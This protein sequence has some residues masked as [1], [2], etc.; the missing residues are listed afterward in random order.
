LGAAAGF[1]AVEL[2]L[3]SA[4]SY[5]GDRSP[6]VLLAAVCGALLAVTR[7]R[8]VMTASALLLMAGWAVVAWT[9]FTAWWAAG[10]TRE[11]PL[12]SADAVYVLAS[13]LQT[14]GEP[15]TVAMSRLLGAMEVLAGGATSRLIVAELPTPAA[16][17]AALARRLLEG[18][19]IEADLSVVG[20]ILNTRD[21]AL[22]VHALC[23]KRGWWRIILVTSPTHSSR[24]AAAFEFT[25]LE[26][27]SRPSM[28][29]RFDL[30]TLDRSSDRIEAFGR[31]LHERLG[32]IVYRQRGWIQ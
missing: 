17:H 10:L 11:D 13:R 24:A 27:I 30:Q 4:V 7:F 29:T 19:A 3:P 25:G 20:P 9:P 1:A 14:D 23:R 22:A 28:E 26:V 2:G 32:A 16:S 12:V 8:T 5:W 21:E 31:V 15:T 6:L 18:L